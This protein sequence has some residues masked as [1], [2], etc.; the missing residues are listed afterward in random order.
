[1]GERR[2]GDGSTVAVD[3]WPRA[4]RLAQL[5]RLGEVPLPPYITEPLADPGR[6]QTVYADR[7]GSVAAPTAGL[8][9]TPS[10]ARPRWREGR[11]GWPS[12][13]LVVGLDTF[14]PVAVDDPADHPMHSERY[15][16]ADEAV[17][18]ACRATKAPAGG[19]WPSAPPPSGRS[20]AAAAGE[21]AGRTELFIRR[22]YP[23]R[24]VDVLLTNFHLPRT[25]LLML[26]DAFVGPR[27]RELY[28]VALDERLPLL[29]VR[30]RHA[31]RSGRPDGACRRSSSR[32][33][34]ARPG[35]ARPPPLAA[36][37]ARPASCPSAPAVPSSTCRPPTTTG[38]ALEIVLANTYHL[39]LRP[40]AETVAALGGLRGFTGWDG[41]LPHRLGRL[42]GLLARPRRRR[43]RCD[44]PLDLRRL[45][46]PPHPRARRGHAGAPRRR[47]PDGA[48]RLPGA[49][50]AA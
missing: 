2:V 42:P 19:S 9:L 32:P 47:H 39:M 24:V 27:W 5:Q 43:R 40:G 10:G 49:P 4:T 18:D 50:C 15:R 3:C 14:K 31:A 6:Y 46:P 21:P 38:S 34:T 26:V 11:S 30:R 17:L 44:V 23:W 12:V 28:E 37:T 48:R 45:A 8:H 35:R 36:P 13:E 16:V 20:R 25:T 1:M 33:P 7:P 29:V 22:P 41:L